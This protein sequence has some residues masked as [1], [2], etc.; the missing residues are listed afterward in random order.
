MLRE[1]Q[2]QLMNGSSIDDVNVYQWF[3]SLSLSWQPNGEI[4]NPRPKFKLN[5]DK[6]SRSAFRMQPFYQLMDVASHV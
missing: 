4:Q 5:T 6:T 1:F 3:L 2:K